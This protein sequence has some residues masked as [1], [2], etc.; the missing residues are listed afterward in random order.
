MSDGAESKRSRIPAFVVGALVLGGLGWVSVRGGGS[1]SRP[2]TLEEQF[3]EDDRIGPLLYDCPFGRPFTE[4]T[5]NMLELLVSK[6]DMGMREPL[7]RAKAELASI[8]PEAIPPLRALF[9]SAYQNPWKQGVVQNVL[10]VCT[11]MK[12]P[13]GI[14]MLRY[15][16]GHPQ[17][18]VRQAALRGIGLHGTASDYD[19]VAGWLPMIQSAQL[20]AAY[21]TCMA[22]LDPQR[23]GGDLASWME[24]GQQEDLYA[25]VIGG[26]LK[27]RDP[28]TAQRLK[29]LHSER[30]DVWSVLLMAA[31]ASLGD[32]EA[33]DSVHKG[34][35]AEQPILRRHAV[36]ALGGIGRARDAS[37][38]LND[39]HP[40]IRATVAEVLIAAEPTEEIDVWLR[41][42]MG[43]PDTRVQETCLT[44]LCERQD[45]LA[46][47]HCLAL[48]Q[49]NPVERGLAL[50]C[51]RSSFPVKP[52]LAEDAYL[53]LLPMVEAVFADG[54]IPIELIQS[55][56]QIPTADCSR[57]LMAKADELSGRIKG[58]PAHRW[59]MG[60]VWNTGS[61]GRELLRE[62]YLIETDPFR[63]IDLIEFI[64]QDH[65]QASRELL[66]TALQDSSLNPFERLYL[67]DRLTRMGP[68]EQVASA[69]KRVYLELTHRQV[70]PA[71]QCLLWIWY[72][73][74]Y[75]LGS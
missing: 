25:H 11:Q 35:H 60:Q 51:L 3:A 5:V 18:S 8:G 63:R 10:A 74:H 66:L 50:R 47:A 57:Y 58:L 31:A 41:D 61:V 71:M 26:L 33:L 9:D 69:L 32:Q 38:L 52:S 29:A 73:Q 30:D 22:T 34:L 43:D 16:L 40:G 48:L 67:A 37:L 36:M 20:R 46:V 56:A 19:L 6:L 75:E 14:D 53:R 13:E 44:S 15:A 27:V 59:L 45:E 42:G 24:S 64:W 55:L 1:G 17:E 49:G 7:M 4:P 12:G 39:P 70:R 62:E 23:F 72:G 21:A 2:L 68:A 28:G 65:S 54:R